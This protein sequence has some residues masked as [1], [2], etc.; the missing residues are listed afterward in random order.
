G[1]LNQNHYILNTG[2][3]CLVRRG[4]VFY[5][6]ARCRRRHLHQSGGV[7]I[8]ADCLRPLPAGIPI[9]GHLEPDYYGYLAT[10][11][12]ELFRLHCAELT[13]QTNASLA[14]R[15]QMAFQDICLPAPQEITRVDAIDLLSVT[16]TM[17]AGVDIG[18]LLAVMMA[19]MPPER[20]NYQQR[21][22]RA[23]RRGGVF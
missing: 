12:G 5:E 23:G 3:I 11:A 17:E 4:T 19:N 13:G 7:C 2:A 22:G 9:A 6:C 16:T 1:V 8:D 18:L 10:Q 20:F 15:R 21:V 14:R